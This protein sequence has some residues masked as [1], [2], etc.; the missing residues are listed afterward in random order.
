MKIYKYV[1][2]HTRNGNIITHFKYRKYNKKAIALYATIVIGIITHL[3]K[4]YIL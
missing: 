1:H 3:T 4:W 2:G